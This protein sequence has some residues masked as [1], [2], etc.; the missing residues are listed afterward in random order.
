M[1]TLR[2]DHT[3]AFLNELQ[4]GS[5]PDLLGLEVLEVGDGLV[6][7]R[8]PVTARH[9]APNGFLHAASVIALADTLCGHGTFAH[10]PAGARAF[11]T[12]ELK[13]NFFGTARSG[14]VLGTATARHRGRTTQVWDAEVSDENGK[15]IA[16]FRCTQMIL[17]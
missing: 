6:R 5:L 17:A 8:M 2:A 1:S 4:R 12:I 14:W 16:A 3:P 11:T 7:G 13:S 15:L 9:L 10:L